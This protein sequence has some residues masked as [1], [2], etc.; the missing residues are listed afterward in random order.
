[1]PLLSKYAQNQKIKYFFK[2]IPKRA[3][4]LEIGSK[5]GWVHNYLKKNG[6]HY[7]VGLD[8]IPPADIVGDIRDWKSLG[9]KE[10]SFDAIIAF[11]VVEHVD[12]FKECFELL[13]PGGRLILTSP[14]PHMD[15]IMRLLELIGLNQKR[16]SP[17]NHLV[18]FQDVPYF[19]TKDIRI[20]GFLSQWGIFTK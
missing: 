15:W 1:M 10:Q 11:E 3:S 12:C 19:K 13:K 17:H 20:V 7:Y 8:I 6:W 18:Y 16:T 4:I 14:V 2:E 5:T 9:L